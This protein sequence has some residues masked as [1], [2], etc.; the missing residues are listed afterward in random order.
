MAIVAHTLVDLVKNLQSF[1][2]IIVVRLFSYHIRQELTVIWWHNCGKTF[3]IP[4][5]H[6]VG[7]DPEYDFYLNYVFDRKKQLFD[8][9]N[10][11]FDD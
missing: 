1:G 7:G 9:E 3:L 2:G 4:Y 10:T 5:S 6:R 8:N 11:H